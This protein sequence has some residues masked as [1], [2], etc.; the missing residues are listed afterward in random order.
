MTSPYS[1]LPSRNFW[2]TGV[3]EQHP[4]TITGLY[5]KKYEIQQQDRIATAGSCFAQHIAVNMRMHGFQVIDA[6]PAPPGLDPETAK[7]F[8][9]G[10]YSARYANIY[11]VRQL[12]QLAQEAYG[13]FSPADLVWESKG[14][15][16]DA[17]R[18]NIEPQGLDSPD[19]VLR[20]RARHLKWVRSVLENANVF[21]F[22]FGLTEGWIHLASGTV[23]P[24]APGTIAGNFDP[25][26]HAFKN[27]THREIYEDFLAFRK[28]LRHR[29]PTVKFLLTVSPVPLTA[30]A[31]AEHV[32]VATTYSK[33]VLRA[34]A[35]QLYFE[36]SDIDYFPSYE[37][38]TA[39][40]TRGMFFE[41]NLRAVNPGGVE[42]VMRTFFSEHKLDLPDQA[43][44]PVRLHDRAVR[45]RKAP[46]RRAK[47]AEEVACEDALLE[48][49]AK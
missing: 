1:N 49:F 44:T 15:F 19:D 10:I 26:V 30:T 33:S 9:Y 8:G 4:L 48:A 24:T 42:Q 13:E 31:S 29:N 7:L 5:R 20:H 25:A 41:A 35:G 37:I 40:F 36:N 12:L 28:L 18:P 34:V 6:E 45:R 17:M 32:L 27:F 23:Y 16:Y 2:K 43:S 38:V 3:S 14:R 11:C 46:M 21:I 39:P 22:T 47:S